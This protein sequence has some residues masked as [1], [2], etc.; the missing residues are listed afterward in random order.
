MA[1][2]GIGRPKRT[3]NPQDYDVIREMLER[4]LSWTQISKGLRMDYTVLR[5]LRDEDE[6]LKRL[7]DEI[8]EVERVALHNTLFDEATKSRNIIAAMFLL[9]CRHGYRENAPVDVAVNGNVIMLPSP[10]SP[11]DYAR[12]VQAAG[13]PTSSARALLGSGSTLPTVEVERG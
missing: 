7:A 4:H 1:I 2:N 9:K 6:T 5:R 10:A 13:T 8:L 11:E 3:L 12:M